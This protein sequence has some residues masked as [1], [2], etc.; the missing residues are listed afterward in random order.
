MIDLAWSSDADEAAAKRADRKRLDAQQAKDATRI[1]LALDQA[2]V[3]GGTIADRVEALCA[4]VLK[5]RQNAAAL[6]RADV[7]PESERPITEHAP[8]D[9]PTVEVFIDPAELAQ[10]KAHRA[11]AAC[12]GPAPTDPARR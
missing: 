11:A 8:A 1:V 9:A 10:A 7:S 6:L 3:P 12:F 4:E 2:N 5:L